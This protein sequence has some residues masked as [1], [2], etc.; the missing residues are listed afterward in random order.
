MRRPPAGRSPRDRGSVSVEM[1]LGYVPLMVLAVLAIVACLR[2]ASAAI[3]VRSAAA[4]A[5]RQ[6]SIARTPTEARLDG[7]DAAS[8]TLAGR[9]LPCQPS[10]I[11]VEP[12]AFV[13]GGQVTAAVA[14]TMSLEDLYG[15]GLPGSVTIRATSRQPLDAYG[16]QP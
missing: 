11:T 6:A 15:L 13:P 2:L 8:I 12:G 14:C 16:A 10:T 5:A 3:D 1:A 9:T 4:A 7:A